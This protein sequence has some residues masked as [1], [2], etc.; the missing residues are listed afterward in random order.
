MQKTLKIGKSVRKKIIVASCILVLI[1]IID[2]LIKLYVKSYFMPGD[3]VPLLGNWFLLEYIE[4]PGMAFGT[5]FGSKVWHKLAL[6]IFRIVAIIGIGIYLFQQIKK[7]AKT[8]FVIAVTLVLAGATGNLIDSMFYDLYFNFDPCMPY[9]GME[10][11]GIFADC[12]GF[13]REVRNTG[14]LMGNVVDM[15]KFQAYWPS[16]VPWIGRGEVFPAIWNLADA[17]IS[18]GV[19]LIFIRQKAYFKESKP[20]TN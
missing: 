13:K 10:G 12:Y 5:T 20:K 4:N 15:F 2:Q 17:S 14:F 11:S 1:L 8:E 18:V 16:W 6:S 19:I 7:Q 9:N 3:T